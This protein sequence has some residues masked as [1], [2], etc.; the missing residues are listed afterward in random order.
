M[1]T[2]LSRY[3]AG[4]PT[5]TCYQKTD[6]IHWCKL[7]IK[8]TKQLLLF[9]LHCVSVHLLQNSNPNPNTEN[10]P[11]TRGLL[12]IGSCSDK[13]DKNRGIT[14]QVKGQLL[15]IYATSNCCCH[16]SPCQRQQ[17]KLGNSSF[18][19]TMIAK[20]TSSLPRHEA[21]LQTQKRDVTQDIPHQQLSVFSQKHVR[22][23]SA[24]AVLI[25]L[26]STQSSQSTQ[27]S[28]QSH[29]NQP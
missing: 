24:E 21:L 15:C 18:H 17:N 11:D 10:L 2:L 28:H 26:T 22:W 1:F 6:V 19:R 14:A 13:C 23:N 8:S 9:A 4:T 12:T 5:F 29:A 16:C 7:K 20:A 25:I 27:D 3:F